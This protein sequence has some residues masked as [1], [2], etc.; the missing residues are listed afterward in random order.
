M[1]EASTLFKFFAEFQVSK[2]L[3]RIVGHQKTNFDSINE[4][5]AFQEDQYGSD[6]HGCYI[7]S[8]QFTGELVILSWAA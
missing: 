4:G 3:S 1:F 7:S 5:N 8:W 6:V 2:A